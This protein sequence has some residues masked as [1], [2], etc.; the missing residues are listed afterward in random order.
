M[1]AM[2]VTMAMELQSI[3]SMLLSRMNDHFE[4]ASLTR[5]YQRAVPGRVRQRRGIHQGAL[6]G[7]KGCPTGV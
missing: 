1:M 5:R 2:V 7:G 4:G 3:F 6:G